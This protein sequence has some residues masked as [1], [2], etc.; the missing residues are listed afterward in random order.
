MYRALLDAAASSPELARCADE[1]AGRLRLCVVGG[2]PTAPKLLAEFDDRFGVTP[3][4]GYGLSETSPI[5][6]VNRS[7]LPHRPGSVGTAVWGVEVGIRDADGGDA[8][9]GCSGEVVIRGTT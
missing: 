1:V 8:A 4:E 9:P 6:V 2:S 7:G 3:L 5:A